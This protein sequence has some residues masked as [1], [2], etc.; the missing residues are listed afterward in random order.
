MKLRLLPSQSSR[1]WH[2]AGAV[3]AG[4]GI[5]VQPNKY[6]SVD[7]V[8]DPQQRPSMFP[9]DRIDEEPDHEGKPY[10]RHPA[11]LVVAGIKLPPNCLQP[12]HH[13]SSTTVPGLLSP[14][15]G[16]RHNRIPHHRGDDHGHHQPVKAPLSVSHRKMIIVTVHKIHCEVLLFMGSSFK[17]LFAIRYSLFAWGFSVVLPDRHCHGDV[18][19]APAP[20]FL[21]RVS[22]RTVTIHKRKAKRGFSHPYSFPSSRR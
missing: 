4:E 17:S 6:Q 3:R 9:P 1:L 2:K 21:H 10:Q 13:A 19:G 8:A 15:S 18:L 11:M 16:A 12:S 20:A 5:E 14:G 7:G 22:L